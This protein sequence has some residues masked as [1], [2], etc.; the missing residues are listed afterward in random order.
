[1][2]KFIPVFGPQELFDGAPEG[3]V[4][5]IKRPFIS[6]V[7]SE[8]MYFFSS[9]HDAIVEAGSSFNF[10]NVILKTNEYAE[11]RIEEVL[12][13]HSDDLHVEH[14]AHI[15]KQ[16]LSEC[17]EKGRGGWE[18]CPIEF[19]SSELIRHINK[20]D[21]VDVA[22]FAM[23]IHERNEKIKSP[24]PKRWTV[25]DQKAGRL[26][27]VGNICALSNGRE[28]EYLGK[29]VGG[30]LHY[31]RFTDDGDCIRIMIN[32]I[33]PIETPDEKAARLENEFRDELYQE[34]PSFMTSNEVDAFNIGA[35]LAY[36]KLK[37]EPPVQ[38]KDGA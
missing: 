10:N 4:I 24:E 19:L 37:S 9:A 20:G 17:R 6:G 26:P 27:E 5:A 28:I 35:R 32:E 13:R 22:N 36:R 29:S 34:A 31:A 21:P 38:A 3:A 8:K 33:H 2:K 15:M 30:T 18:E 25:A 12:D 23:M 7:R 16:K 1:M 14:F 11:R